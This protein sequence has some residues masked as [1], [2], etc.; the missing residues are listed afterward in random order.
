M[1][2][3]LIKLFSAFL[4]FAASGLEVSAGAA[5]IASLE[6]KVSDSFT[7]RYKI[8]NDASSNFSLTAFAITVSPM[9]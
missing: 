8:T 5:V 4:L 7:Y 9:A 3:N 6:T 2:H 1:E